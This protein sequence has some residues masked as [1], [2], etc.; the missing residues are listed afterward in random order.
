[1]IVDDHDAQR[2]SHDANPGGRGSALTAGGLKCRRRPHPAG[3]RPSRR[4]GASAR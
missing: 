2:L 1:V 3:S 4:C